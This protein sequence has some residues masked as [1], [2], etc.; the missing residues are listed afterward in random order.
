MS[1]CTL[2]IWQTKFFLQSRYFV[3]T[4]LVFTLAILKS[5]HLQLALFIIIIIT[6]DHSR[7]LIPTVLSRGSYI[8]QPNYVIYAHTEE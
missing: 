6:I 5:S 7:V 4:D 1:F 2:S 3:D 8:L